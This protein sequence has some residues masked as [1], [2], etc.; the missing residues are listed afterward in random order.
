[1]NKRDPNCQ[2]R[3]IKEMDERQTMTDNHP[4]TKEELEQ[5]ENGCANP[6]ADSCEEYKFIKSDGA[7]GFHKHVIEI[8]SRPDPLALLEAWFKW[9]CTTHDTCIGL[10]DATHY[11]IIQSRTN[12]EAVRQQGVK[13]GWL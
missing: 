5:I 7:C 9:Y 4:V 8:A 12:P 6:A 1:M 3:L 11:M 2:E 13:E 10:K